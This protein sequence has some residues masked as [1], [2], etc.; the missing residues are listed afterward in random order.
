M[1]DAVPPLTIDRVRTAERVAEALR[2]Q[3]LSGVFPLGAPMRDVELSAHAGVSRTTMREAL[4]LLARE[5]LLSHALH[6]GMEVARIAAGDVRDIYAARRVLERAGLEAMLAAPMPPLADLERSLATMTEAAARRDM[7]GVIEA[8][9]AFHTTIVAAAGVR[10]LT[11]AETHVLM[12]LRL[13][14]SVTDRAYGDP[15]EQVQQ[16]QDLL[17]AMRARR[18]DAPA[19]LEAH[20]DEAAALVAC[21]LAETATDRPGRSRPK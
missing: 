7:R 10:R 3:L 4:A 11:D 20:L 19:L 9:V 16:H 17:E 12:E 5:G 8:D 21:V 15:A 6:R 13:A 1:N 18:P 14:L 2:E